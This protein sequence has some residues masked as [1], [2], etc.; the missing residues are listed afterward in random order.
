MQFKISFFKNVILLKSSFKT[1]DQKK[2]E[3]FKIFYNLFSQGL[4]SRASSCCKHQEN[5]PFK[6]L[7]NSFKSKPAPKTAIPFSK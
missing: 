4:G 1:L 6:N 3:N 7:K 2:K 5:Q